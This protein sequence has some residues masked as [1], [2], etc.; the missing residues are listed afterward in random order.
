ML[1]HLAEADE[2]LS[3]I[4]AA[5]RRSPAPASNSAPYYGFARPG[6]EFLAVLARAA[7]TRSDQNGRPD[8]GDGRGAGRRGV[9][10]RPATF[11][12]QAA[13]SVFTVAAADWIATPPPT[14]R[15]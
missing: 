13:L 12:A 2:S 9:P 5:V 11:A 14:S 3:A 1:A 7:G 15:P 8:R 10:E 4:D 6:C